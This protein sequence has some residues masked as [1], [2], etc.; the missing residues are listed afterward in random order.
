MKALKYI[1][2]VVMVFAVSQV[3][4]Q[5]VMTIYNGSE[6]LYDQSIS[7]IDSVKFANSNAAIYQP[8]VDFEI[9]I[10]SMDSIV[11]TNAASDKVYIIFNG[12]S[13]TV[14]NPYSASGITIT[15][16]SGHVTVTSTTTVS[17]IEYNILG[18]TTNGS[19]TVSSDQ[20]ARFVFGGVD[21]TNPSGAAV[22]LTGTAVHTIFLA[23]GTTSK[24][25]DSSSGTSNAAFIA[26]GG[27]NIEGSGTMQISGYKKHALLSSGTIT[28]NSGNINVPTAASDAIH[29]ADYTQAGGAVTLTPSG[30]GI[31]TDN[32]VNIN[33]GTAT[34]TA[35]Q[36][37]TKGIKGTTINANGG[38]I[39]VIAS[40]DQSKGLKSSADVNINGATVNITASGN[41]ILEASGSGYDPSYCSG[42]KTDGA[43]VMNSG[44]LAIT[45]TST[46]NGGKGISSDGN[47]TVNGGTINITTN[48]NGAT[49][50]NESGVSDSYSAC[51]IK[52]DA[53]IYLNQ[54]NITCNSTGTA[55][56][57]V[58]ADSVLTLGVLNA[59]NDLLTLTVNTS[60]AKFWV[61]GS[62]D[63]ADYANPKAVK[64]EGNL[65]VNSG[66]I[67][68]T[69]TTDGGEGLE[70]KSTMY[71]KGGQVTIT[72]V[73]DC[74]NATTA[75]NISGGSL[76]LS[77]S[78]NDAID[79][80]GTLSVSGGLTVAN[81]A[82]APEAGF[83]CD[84]SN[85]AITGG[86]A[87]GT[88]G[89]TSTP[90]T[91]TSSQNYLN[92]TAT[93]GSAICIKNSS[94]TV[95]M[96]MQLPSISTSGGGPG[97]GS[98]GGMVVLYTNPL[99]TNGT[100]T[101]QYGGSITGGTAVKGYYT[102]NGTYSGGSSRTFTVS[103]R[104]TSVSA[105]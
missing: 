95:I 82:G 43:F 100:Y 27:A 63:D 2:A 90:S 77:S 33:A 46:N 29:A 80:N 67:T 36:A 91:S 61:S 54:G 3:N 37:D 11:F 10:T 22:N 39:T 49:Y 26:V 34:I 64:S 93:S 83:D 18:S 98:S 16:A 88:G 20:P 81:G 41:V 40:G 102:T 5:N 94:G 92:I 76:F 48:G 62:G 75:L 38:T 52:S 28:L 71:I 19:L 105:R 56:K 103:S 42:I 70:S 87:V 31:D 15:E 72:T 104:A 99:I 55:G 57:G 101:I 74:I 65:T 60:G 53:N 59:S 7:D 51:A 44:T 68:I 13:A 25:A 21:M 47:I 24:F 35:S 1:L 45:C 79:S 4:A 78:G 58:S 84:Q 97:G 85:F 14:V 6:V 96:M 17:G 50:V 66:I 73:D 32:T 12:S 86:I 23:K 30:D 69:C 8:S 89:S 9:P